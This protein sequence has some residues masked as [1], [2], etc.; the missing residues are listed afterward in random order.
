MITMLS[1]L[2]YK[3]LCLLRNICTRPETLT[4]LVLRFAFCLDTAPSLPLV[5]LS[6][7]ASQAALLQ[8][9]EL[10]FVTRQV[11]CQK[12]FDCCVVCN[13]GVPD[14]ESAAWYV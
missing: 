14:A 12:G 9:R 3:A 13:T 8:W 2:W 10:A 7:G 6:R 1:L 11:P 4:Y 5:N